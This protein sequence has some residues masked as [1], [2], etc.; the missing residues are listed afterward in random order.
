MNG[1]NVNYATSYQKVIDKKFSPDRTSNDLWN[2]P[3][4]SQVKWDGTHVKIPTLDVD[5]G[6]TPRA[7]R[8]LGLGQVAD[9]KNSYEDKEITF[10]REWRCVVD[11]IDTIGTNAVVTIANIT[12]QHNDSM[13]EEDDARMYSRLYQEKERVNREQNTP[14]RGIRTTPLDETNVLQVFD[15]MMDEMDESRVKG[16]RIL[17][18]SKHVKQLLNRADVTNRS[19]TIDGSGSLNRDITAL[20]NVVI[21]KIPSYLL[22]TNYNWDSR[23]FQLDPNAKD[24]EMFLIVN[25]CQVAPK[26][27]FY[28]GLQDASA[29]TNGNILYYENRLQDVFLLDRKAD[30][31]SVVV[32]GGAKDVTPQ[33]QPQEN[34]A[35]DTKQDT[36]AD[37]SKANDGKADSKK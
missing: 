18:V 4:N 20:D 8:S 24:I 21:K 26:R 12:D 13:V 23:G 29:L 6:S 1:M 9:Y 35:Q 30:A 15:D 27:Y 3:S 7:S 2:S 34:N 28:A 25:G 17:Y 31:Y 14:G 19:A 16:Q 10:S 11:P 33:E 36:K 37:D 5:G 22:K 32:S